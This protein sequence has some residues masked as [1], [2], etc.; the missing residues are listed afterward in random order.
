[1][2]KIAL[3]FLASIFSISSWADC[4]CACVNGSV[5]ALCTSSIDLKPICPA[6]I[7]PITPPSVRPIDTPTVPPIGTS[8]CRNQQVYN[9]QKSQYEWKQ[10]CR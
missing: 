7:C 3:G 9:A 8:S 10:I 6:Q 1:M 5:Q 4:R 2:Q